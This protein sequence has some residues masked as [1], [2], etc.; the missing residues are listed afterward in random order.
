MTCPRTTLDPEKGVGRIC[1]LSGPE[2]R[3]LRKDFLGGPDLAIVR[4]LGIRALENMHSRGA[5]I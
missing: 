3:G 5:Q 4:A 2:M 1:M